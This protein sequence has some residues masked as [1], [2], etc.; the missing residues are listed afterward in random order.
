M[1]SLFASCKSYVGRVDF[2]KPAKNAPLEFS[3]PLGKN[4]LL[5]CHECYGFLIRNHRC[6]VVYFFQFF[7]FCSFRLVIDKIFKK[8]KIR[9]EITITWY[10]SDST[11][12]ALFGKIMEISNGIMISDT[13]FDFMKNVVI[14]KI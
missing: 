5:C 3:L 9:G 14:L 6:T 12:C 11:V 1:L 4:S 8:I 2:P 10:F 7:Q 13:I